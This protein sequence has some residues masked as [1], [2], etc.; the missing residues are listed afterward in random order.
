[1]LLHIPPAFHAAKSWTKCMMKGLLVM[2]YSH[3][4]LQTLL[5]VVS[6]EIFKR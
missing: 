6:C 5:N 3:T 4:I 1:M 2:V